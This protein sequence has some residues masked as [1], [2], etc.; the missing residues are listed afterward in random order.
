MPFLGNIPTSGYRRIVKQTITG[1]GGT[2]YD[3]DNAVNNENELEVFINNVRQ[4]PGAAY[5]AVSKEITFTTALESSDNC[6]I[7]FQGQANVTNLIESGNIANGSVTADKLDT[8]YAKMTESSTEPTGAVAGD[9]WFDNVNNVVKSYNGSKWEQLSNRFTAI[10]GTVVEAEGYRI[11][12]F[13]SS[14]TF[15]VIDGSGGVEALIIA[16]GGGGGNGGLTLGEGG[17]GGGGAGGVIQL[18]SQ[19]VSTGSY[20]I[21]VGAG[22]VGGL[23]NTNGGNSSVLGFTAAGGG[24]GGRA[25]GGSGVS[26][27][28]GGGGAGSSSPSSTASGGSGTSGQG[29]NGGLGAGRSGGGGGGAGEVGGNSSGGSP[30]TA[31]DG[32]DGIYSSITGAQ[33]SYAGGGGA[34]TGAGTPGSGGLGWGGNGSNDGEDDAQAGGTNKGAGGGGGSDTGTGFAGAGGSGI[35]II[36]YPI[37]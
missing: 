6:Y 18:S 29:F 31:G 10:G 27:G 15:S 21:V 7:V 19:F 8:R 30:A 20:S 36:R 3:L 1:N 4:E 16:G 22:G 11:H 34:G 17:G 13:T 2:V 23:N 28:S 12:T 37:I 24:G 5:T 33:A 14:G 35:V 32:G 25:N 9:L 26:G